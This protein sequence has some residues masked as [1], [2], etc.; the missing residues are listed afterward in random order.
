MESLLRTSGAQ[1][2]PEI[3]DNSTRALTIAEETSQM[4]I[5]DD[6]YKEARPD[7]SEA[8]PST[9]TSDTVQGSDV[10]ESSSAPGAV[11]G[12]AA[13]Q[14]PVYKMLLYLMQCYERTAVQDR[15]FPKVLHQCLD[16]L[17]AYF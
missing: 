7:Q 8:H 10:I 3:P 2:V 4:V 16:C 17:M 12:S 13:T 11:V 1:E 14:D 15:N 5:N 6:D 9:D